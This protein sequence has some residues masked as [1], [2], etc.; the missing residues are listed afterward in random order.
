MD[1]EKAGQ[2]DWAISGLKTLAW[3]Y[4]IT[5][6]IGI[7]VLVV[8][9][10]D[11]TPFPEMRKLLKDNSSLIIG[12]LILLQVF[13]TFMMVMVI[14]VIGESLAA[15]REHA[16]NQTIHLIAIRKNTQRNDLS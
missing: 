8:A 2:D 1:L 13:L 5:A 4:L 12:V 10:I 14:A 11:G 7:V 9:F 6:I 3:C 16:A 15:I